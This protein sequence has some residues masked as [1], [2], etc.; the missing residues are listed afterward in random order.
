MPIPFVPL[1]VLIVGLLMWALSANVRVQ[2]MGRIAYAVGLF[3]AVAVVA[4]ALLHV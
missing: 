4:R 3:F 1:A 2:E